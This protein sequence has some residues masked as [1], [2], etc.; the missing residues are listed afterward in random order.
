MFEATELGRK[1]SKQEYKEA[2]PQLREQLL[3]AQTA[4]R[5]AGV[6]VFILVEGIDSTGKG[7]VINLLNQWF[8][9]RGLE[10]NGFGP[11]TD[12]EARRPRFWRYWRNFPAKGRI[13]LFFGSWYTGE[14]IKRATK[15]QQKDEFDAHMQ[16]ISK[17]ETMLAREGALILKF[18]LHTSEETLEKKLK[19][20]KEEQDEGWLGSEADRQVL[21][22]YKRYNKAAERA[23]R[24]TDQVA[25]PWHLI[26]AEDDRYRDITLARQILETMQTRLARESDQAQ[27][28]TPPL[29]A[30]TD[31]DVTT[32]LDQIDLTQSLEKKD[33]DN[34]LAEL[35]SQLT[36]L[37]WRAYHQGISLILVFEGWDAA[38]KGGAIRRIMQAID[39]RIARVI[40]IAAPTDEEL[41]HHYLW[42]FW[43]HIPLAG[44][45]TIY[46][47]SWYGR[48]LVERVEGFAGEPEWRRAYAEINDF[49]EQIGGRGNLLLKFWLHIDADE[50]LSRFQAR[51][52]IPYKNYK[53]TDEDWRN[54]ERW[55]DYERAVHDMVERTSTE[56]APWTLVA[57]NDKHFA[58]ITVLET[59]CK[60]LAKALK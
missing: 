4:L 7:E 54:R 5:Q 47:R 50:Q 36:R 35:Q 55:H 26:E 20:H 24:L 27:P 14:L 51:E 19:L 10:V 28:E 40:S 37:S 60:Q 13:G 32:I 15:H 30:D 25:A 59:I 6:A 17:L 1:L 39:A 56:Y 45:H 23:V 38:G 18:W 44:R 8:D 57:G 16:G 3:M 48:V 22:N 46:D 34:R 11:K 58:R 12:E 31:D 9:T 41:S 49:E 53:I 29:Q 21:L 42:R 43:R 52:K 33:Y 2:V